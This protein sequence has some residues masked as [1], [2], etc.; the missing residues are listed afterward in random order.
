[1]QN[2]IVANHHAVSLTTAPKMIQARDIQRIGLIVQNRDATAE[3]YLRSGGDGAP[4]SYLRFQP[5]GD[6]MQDILP[7][8][9]ELWAYANVD[10]TVL[11]VVNKYVGAA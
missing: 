8:T 5:G 4:L 1:M 3:I 2:N 9:Q 6:M 10:G 11:T 7:P